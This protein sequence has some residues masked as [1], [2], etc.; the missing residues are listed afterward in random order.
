ME[1]LFVLALDMDVHARLVIRHPGE[2]EHGAGCTRVVSRRQF[3][4]ALYGQVGFSLPNAQ[5]LR[6]LRLRASLQTEAGKA[7]RSVPRWGQHCVVSP[8]GAQSE[9]ERGEWKG[10]GSP[11]RQP[12]FDHS[13]ITTRY[14]RV[15]AVY[16][17]VVKLIYI[18]F[19]H[20]VHNT[21]HVLSNS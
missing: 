20:S 13:T 15:I 14:P 11:D 12:L 16:S 17:S 3:R 10:H 7:V 19:S 4:R 5:A 2:Y 9:L 8:S 21:R 18:M 1:L 6:T